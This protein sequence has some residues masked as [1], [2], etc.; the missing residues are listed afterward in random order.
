MQDPYDIWEEKFIA[1]CEEKLEE[2][3]IPS[4]VVHTI[5]ILL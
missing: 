5:K 2:E 1:I 4:L 3:P